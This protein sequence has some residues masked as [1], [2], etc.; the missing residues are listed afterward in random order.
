M[1]ILEYT[2]IAI[3]LL[4]FVLLV[5]AVIKNEVTFRNR[6]RISDAICDYDINCIREDRGSDSIPCNHMES[7]DDT[8]SRFWDWGYK[9]ILPE[10][11]FKKIEKYIK[12]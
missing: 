10:E 2:I 5:L 7:Y 9:H 1:I 4:V 11:D 6:M 12:K 8:F 3:F